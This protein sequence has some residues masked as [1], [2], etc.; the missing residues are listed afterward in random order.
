MCEDLSVDASR[1]A[2]EWA[3]LMLT[4]DEANEALAGAHGFTFTGH[5]VC[6]AMALVNLDII[7]REGLVA[8]ARDMGEWML[9][10]LKRLEHARPPLVIEREQA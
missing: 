4:V 8:R 9:T 5:P 6:A 7:E 2:A 3:G 1:A 10:E